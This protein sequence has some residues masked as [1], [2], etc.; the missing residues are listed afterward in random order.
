MSDTSLIGVL[1]ERA[2]LQPEDIAYTFIDYDHEW[3]GVA[4]TL[5]W[6]QLN[7]RVRNLAVEIRAARVRSVTVPSSWRRR[8]LEYVI[9]FL[10]SLEAGIIAV[11]LS[12][13]MIGQH[14]ER[15]VRGDQGFG[16]VDHPDHLGGRRHGRRVRGR[17]GRRGRAPTVIEVDAL[18]LDARRT[19]AVQ[20]RGA[21]RDRV[22]AVHLRVHPHAGRRDGRPTGT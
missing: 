2:S 21:A 3:D 22:S 18:D 16:A 9:G 5:T 14:D 12:V 20:P 6:A 4:T 8:A 17:L 11:P 15:V 7:R 1:R 10:A 19:V 13:P